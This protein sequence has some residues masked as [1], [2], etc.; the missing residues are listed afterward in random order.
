MPG[1]F[2]LAELAVRFGLELEG[3]PDLRVSHVATLSQATPESVSFLAN[4]RYRRSLATTRAG[5]VV[6]SAED[7][8]SCPVAA[9]I[10]PNPYLSYARI[11]TLMYPEPRVV[12]GVHPTAVIAAGARVAASAAVG[13]LAVIEE[14]AE[15]GERAMVGPGCVVQRDAR[16]GADSQLVASVNLYPGVVLGCRVLVHAGAV[17]GADGF[18]FAPDHGTWFKVPQVG[19]VRIGDDVEIGA[20]TTVDRGA[21][22]DTVVEDGAK[23]DNQ[24][25]VGHNVTIGAHTA[26]AA[27]TGISG[28]TTIGRR[29][30]IGGMVGFAGHLTIADDVVITGCSLVS[31]SI[32]EAGSYSSGMP[33]VPTRA[34]RRMVAHF[35]RF[36]EKE[37]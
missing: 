30:M 34:W 32:R 19:S 2:S 13:P 6:L 20:N 12:P 25:Q 22:G 26:I 33:T 17:I 9:L 4:S 23:L 14:G 29:C 15:I 18:G 37:R 36:G 11:A 35:R 7:A 1:D 21:I 16:L 31:A 10:G 3:D 24:I 5:A 28:S 8:G 27:C